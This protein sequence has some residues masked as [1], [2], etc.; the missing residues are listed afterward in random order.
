MCKVLIKEVRKIKKPAKSKDAEKPW[1]L[2]FFECLVSVDGSPEEAV[3]TVKTFEDDIAMQISSLDAGKTLEF[4][5]KKEG[6]AAPFEF[7]I[8]KPKPPKAQGSFKGQ[9]LGPTNRQCVL[10]VAVELNKAR[11]EVTGDIPTAKEIIATAE[12]L[13]VWLE[14]GAK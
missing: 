10:K 11:S 7:L 12:E 1:T 3:R 2:H 8:Q 6:D 4:E 14:G 13:L 9:A 5:A